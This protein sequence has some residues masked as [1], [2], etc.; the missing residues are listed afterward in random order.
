[1]SVTAIYGDGWE[2]RHEMGTALWNV[3]KDGKFVLVFSSRESAAKY[4]ASRRAAQ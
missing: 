1:M 4:V 2:V 3:W